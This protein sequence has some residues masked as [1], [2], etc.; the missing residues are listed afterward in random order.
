[1]MLSISLLKEAIADKQ[2]SLFEAVACGAKYM[3]RAEK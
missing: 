2:G 1:M 3:V